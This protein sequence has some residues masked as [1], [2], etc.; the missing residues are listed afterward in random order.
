[1][2]VLVVTEYLCD[3]E[4]EEWQHCREFL[5]FQA[6]YDESCNKTTQKT[7]YTTKYCEGEWRCHWMVASRRGWICDRCQ[8]TNP[9]LTLYA[10]CQKA[11]CDHEFCLKCILTIEGMYS[12]AW[13][14]QANSISL[15]ALVVSVVQSQHRLAQNT[16]DFCLVGLE[17]KRTK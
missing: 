13:G 15:T 4:A 11:G 3:H 6:H 17:L 9:G 5:D 12:G 16:I 10:I 1:M 2:C 14:V 8:H 7:R